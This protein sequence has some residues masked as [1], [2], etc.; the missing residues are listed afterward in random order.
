[1]MTIVA[2]WVRTGLLAA[3]L[4]ATAGCAMLGGSS[5]PQEAALTL[6][7]LQ[8]ETVDGHRAV[9]LR[10]SGLPRRVTHASS[11]SPA[12]IE[13]FLDGPDGEG[14]FSEQVL[15]Q[16]DPQIL[17]VRVTRET[18]VLHVVFDIDGDTPPAYRVLEM[19]DWILLRFTSTESESRNPFP[20]LGLRGGAVCGV[21]RRRHTTKYDSSSLLASS[22]SALRRARSGDSCSHSE[23]EG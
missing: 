10:L 22:P 13:I 23:A 18:G 16:T 8:I 12:R 21:A 7:N 3:V 14:D 19:A 4:L 5:S 9:L 1:M 15:P 6:R 11:S 17:Q 2:K 20:S